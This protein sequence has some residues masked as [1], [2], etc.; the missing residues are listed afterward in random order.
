MV[1]VLKKKQGT[2]VGKLPLSF[3]D[4]TWTLKSGEGV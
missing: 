3:G 1:S 2:K 4:E